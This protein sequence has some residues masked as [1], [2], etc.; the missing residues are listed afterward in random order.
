MNVVF[1]TGVLEEA[2]EAKNHY[3][4][5]VEGQQV[6]FPK[7]SYLKLSVCLISGVRASAQPSRVVHRLLVLQQLLQADGAEVP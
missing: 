1:A 6:G 4:L 3:E 5:E 7:K 2:Q